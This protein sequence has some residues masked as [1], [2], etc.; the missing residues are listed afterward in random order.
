VN[1]INDYQK[2]FAFLFVS[3]LT[4]SCNQQLWH[5]IQKTLGSTKIF[6]EEISTSK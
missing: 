3:F 5:L 4:T 6:R 1:N 2:L